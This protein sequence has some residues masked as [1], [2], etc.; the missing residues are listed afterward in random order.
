MELVKDRRKYLRTLLKEKVQI[1]HNEN[2]I[3]D[4][5]EDISEG[6]ARIADA[7]S[8]PLHEAVVK[9][10]VP[11]PHQKTH[12]HTLCLFWGKIIWRANGQMGMAFVDPPS[13]SLHRLRELLQD[14]Q[15]DVFT[16]TEASAASPLFQ[17]PD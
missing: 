12:R 10:F 9:L 5:L 16:P 13:D 11:V 14:G 7:A 4:Q 8:I 17:S 15:Q 3:M 2:V 6:G 1:V